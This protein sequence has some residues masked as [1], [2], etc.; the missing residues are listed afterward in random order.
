MVFTVDHALNPF[1]AQN[2][3]LFYNLLFETVSRT[4]QAMAK[5]ELGCELGITLVL[6]TLQSLVPA[7]TMPWML[8]PP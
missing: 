5:A 1:I 8:P 3:W 4:L 7:I 2:P 6:H